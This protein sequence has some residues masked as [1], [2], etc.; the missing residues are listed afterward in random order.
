MRS[1]FLVCK[2]V[3]P[4]NALAKI[5]NK[6]GVQEIQ[7]FLTLAAV[8]EKCNGISQ[9]WLGSLSQYILRQFRLYAKLDGVTIFTLLLKK[10]TN[11]QL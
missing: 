4:F 3:E 1:N 8:R 7:S 6:L 2:V 9:F 5:A 10:V 11:V